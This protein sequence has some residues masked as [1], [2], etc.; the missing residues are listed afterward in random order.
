MAAKIIGY[1]DNQPNINV[2]DGP[3]TANSSYELQSFISEASLLLQVSQIDSAFGLSVHR[4]LSSK[5][6]MGQYLDVHFLH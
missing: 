1:T 3:G 6:A 2:T 4:M 5:A